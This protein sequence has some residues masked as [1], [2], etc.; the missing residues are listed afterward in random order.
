MISQQISNSLIT[1]VI[2]KAHTSDELYQI[3]LLQ[4]QAPNL[5]IINTFEQELLHCKS[6]WFTSAFLTMSGLNVLHSQLDNLQRKGIRG[7]VLLSQY[8]NFTDPAALERLATFDNLEI[9]IDTASD[10]HAKAYFFEYEDHTSMILGSSNLTANALTRNQELNLFVRALPGSKIIHDLIDKKESLFNHATVLNA[11]YLA[12]YSEIYKK[13]RTIQKQ[14][15]DLSRNQSSKSLKIYPNKMQTA[16]LDNLNALRKN[17]IRKALLISATGTGKTYLSAFDAYNFKSKNFLF[18]VHRE[19]ILNTAKNDYAKV[20]GSDFNA[21]IFSGSNKDISGKNYIFATIQT[22]SRTSNLEQLSPEQFDYIV[23]DEVHRAA[24]DTYLKVINYFKPK[25]LLG[26]TATP[27]RTD[28]L[29]IFKLFDH[30]IAYEIRL[31]E[32]MAADM[33]CPFHYFGV[34]EL[35]INGEVVDDKT[36]FKYLTS[37]DRIQQI[38]SKSDYFSTDSGELRALVFC[39]RVDEA[40][41]LASKM[42][43]LGIRSISLTGADSEETRSKAIES[44]NTDEPD[45]IKMIFTVDILNEGIDIPRINQIIMIRATA[46]AII[47]IQQLG[48]GLRKHDSKEFLTVIDFIGN[49][50]KNFLIPMALFADSS[51]NKDKLRRLVS[52][53]GSILPGSSSIHFDKVSKDRIFESIN[54]AKF[55]LKKELIQDYKALKSRLGR[56]PMMLDF[57]NAQ[58][59]DPYNYVIYAKSF[60][61]FIQDIETFEVPLTALERATLEFL[62]TEINNAK[63][64]HESL[65]LSMLLNSNTNEIDITAY[66]E[67]LKIQYQQEITAE[68]ITS[69]LNNLN[70]IFSPTDYFKK[71]EVIELIQVKNGKFVASQ[72]FRN[73]LNISLFKQYLTDNIQYALTSFENLMLDQDQNKGFIYY[74]KYSRKDAFRILNWEK[75]Q[76]PQ[77]VGGYLASK[78]KSNCPIFVTYHKA[79]DISESTKYEDRFLDDIHFEWMSKSKRKLSSPDVQLIMH[80]KANNTLLPL[81]IKK[82]NDE[83]VEFYFMGYL[84]YLEDTAHDS[85]I[86]SENG[87]IA[88]VKMQFKLDRAVD[89]HLYHYLMAQ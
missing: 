46:S 50:E 43:K 10:L 35:S 83:G 80:A 44:I 19:N 54:N 53:G 82:D 7:K 86:Q 66:S 58:Y 41:E 2:D 88:V 16:A 22:L 64:P 40:I 63:R 8:L 1:S 62:S 28:S 61:S 13:T 85:T 77:N 32:A 78:D 5:K 65:V 51:Y 75:N 36:D 39:S 47:F 87:P 18:I 12:Q 9:R 11:D 34:A 72:E 55:Q 67:A 45:R 74:A 20:F 3:Q 15:L 84:E 71:N 37:D 49:Y 68:V 59:R 52:E 24:A 70:M 17:N 69:I 27:E 29:D 21:T 57:S 60:Y 4:N 23:I 89:S 79:D 33:V 56:A 14:V 38:K 73:M 48:R 31:K 81:F 30:N 6:F 76:N 26:M 42:S 25:F